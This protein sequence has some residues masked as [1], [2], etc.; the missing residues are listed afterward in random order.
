MAPQIEFCSHSIVDSKAAAPG[1]C[2]RG[3]RKKGKK[4]INHIEE[5]YI[6]RRWGG[7]DRSRDKPYS[8][9]EDRCV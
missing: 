1:H 4:E 8:R 6:C 5:G 9:T 2:G 7:L 3:R